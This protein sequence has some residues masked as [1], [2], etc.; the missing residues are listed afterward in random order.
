MKSCSF[1]PPLAVLSDSPSLS[2]SL[3]LFL[4]SLLQPP[5]TALST[6]LSSSSSSSS[7]PP[8]L[9]LSLSLSLIAEKQ[10]MSFKT[11]A[12]KGERRLEFVSTNLHIQRLRLDQ[13]K[14]NVMNTLS[15]LA[16]GSAAAMLAPVSPTSSTF[17][18]RGESVSS[19][20][21][22]TFLFGRGEQ[23]PTG[24]L[25]PVMCVEIKV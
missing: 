15:N 7:P 5:S 22:E 1:K 14:N 6:S 3:H 18:T 9:P 11:S 19:E 17:S 12:A 16:S 25:Q 2:S 20:T 10:E 8:P 4:Y 13:S 23:T 24:M 21:S